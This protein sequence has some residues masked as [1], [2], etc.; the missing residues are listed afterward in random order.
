MG[1]FDALLGRSKPAKAN[2]D[3]LFSVPQAALTLEA[4]GG[5]AFTGIGSVCY[6]AN[7]GAAFRTTETECI[8]LLRATPD[9]SAALTEDQFGFSWIEVAR[10]VADVAGLVTDLH[11]VNVSLKDAGFGRSLLC[12]LVNFT[13]TEGQSVALVYLYKQ[14]TFFPF[15]PVGDD[16]RDN[17][18]E[19]MV[20]GLVA[21]DIPIE[22]DL[23]RWFALWGAPGL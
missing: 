6:R 8:E 19:L 12:S 1:L 21:D 2:L 5:F 23:S 4:S 15:A 20:R 11:T 18:L 9:S 22:P 10:S 16:V 17:E 14:G 3:D 7:E 13:T